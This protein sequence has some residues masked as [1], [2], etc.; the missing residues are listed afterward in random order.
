MASP[1][2]NWS[3]ALNWLFEELEAA[4]RLYAFVDYYKFH[5]ASL[6]NESVLCYRG[7]PL[8]E[9]SRALYVN[10]CL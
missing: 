4:G 3:I 6:R 9:L 5:A 7:A 1:V 2:V 8:R 10:H